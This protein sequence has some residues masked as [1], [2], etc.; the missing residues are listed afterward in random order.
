MLDILFGGRRHGQADMIDT[1]PADAEWRN[2]RP[3][4][5]PAVRA[6]LAEADCEVETGNGRLFAR[7]GED[8]IISYGAEERSVVRGDIFERTY[9]PLGGGLFR[10]RTD[11]VFRCFTLK[12]DATINTL[13]G[14]QRAEAGDWVIQGV[15]GE[16]WPVPRDKALEK[17]ETV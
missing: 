9:E 15:A 7:G 12:H 4:P 13:E 3:K 1:P 17:Y 6:R 5:T 14:P 2:V 10:K 11:V 8:Y 16:L